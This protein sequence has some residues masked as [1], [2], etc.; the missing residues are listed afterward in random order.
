MQKLC[1]VKQIAGDSAHQLSYLCIIVKSKRKL[2]HMGKDFRTHIVFHLRPHHMAI[3]A[4]K[5][6]AE[7]IDQQKHCQKHS[8]IQKSF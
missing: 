4:D 5:K 8:N 1:N 6:A 7:Q 2:L 3:I